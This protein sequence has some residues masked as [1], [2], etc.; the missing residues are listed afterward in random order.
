MGQSN[1]NPFREGGELMSEYSIEGRQLEQSLTFLSHKKTK[2]EYLLREQTFNDLREFALASERLKK[3]QPIT[4][5]HL[6][7]LH[8]TASPT[9][10]SRNAQRTTSAPTSTRSTPSGTTPAS[11]SPTK[12]PQGRSNA[13]PSRPLSCNR[14]W[15]AR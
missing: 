6:T 10:A 3:R 14:S 5:P 11:P 12:S 8:R 15:P 13:S 7:N 4:S 1:S 9:Q 2:K